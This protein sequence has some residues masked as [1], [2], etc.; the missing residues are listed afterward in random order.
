MLIN[1]LLIFQARDKYIIQIL[2]SF[3]AENKSLSLNDW[4]FGYVIKK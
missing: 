2:S 3:I 4:G 1:D